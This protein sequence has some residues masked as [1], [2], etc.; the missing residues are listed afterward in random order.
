M[1]KF[2][3]P[4]CDTGYVGY[5]TRHLFSRIDEHRHQSSAIAKHLKSCH[6]TD[7]KSIQ[8][9]FSVL[10]KCKNKIDCLIHEMLFI[11]DL[12]PS[13]NKQS[14]PITLY[15]QSFYIVIVFK[16]CSCN[17]YNVFCKCFLFFSLTPSYS[18]YVLPELTSFFLFVYAFF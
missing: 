2:Q 11:R 18:N 10:K 1:Y 17:F 13:L 14:D 8:N 3:C 7:T 5:T 12:N 4:L 9:N 16:Y 15:C 6:S